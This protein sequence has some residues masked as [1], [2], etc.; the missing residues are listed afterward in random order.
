M[1][2]DVT[3]VELVVALRAVVVLDV[4]VTVADEALAHQ[5]VV[6]LVA[7][8]LQRDVPATEQAYAEDTENG[9]DSR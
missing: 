9:R 1:R 8:V 3:P 7:R 6:R 4:D 2:V 5:E